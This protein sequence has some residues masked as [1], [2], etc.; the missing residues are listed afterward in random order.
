MLEIAGFAITFIGVL[1]DLVDSY[2]DS[3]K[4]SE[5]EIEV[6][7]DWLELA[8]EKGVLSHSADDY[9]WVAERRVQTAELKGSLKVVIAANSE[10]RIRYRIVQGTTGDRLILMRKLSGA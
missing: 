1:N 8:L 9:A 4:W 10:G 7:G 6:D 5:T 3:A 2:R